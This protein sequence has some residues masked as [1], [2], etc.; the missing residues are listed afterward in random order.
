VSEERVDP[1]ALRA[2]APDFETEVGSAMKPPSGN[3]V[4][5]GLGTLLG[6]LGL[7]PVGDVTDEA[8]PPRW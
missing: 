1:V 2:D 3:T 4:V 5:R 6:G 7:D 8:D